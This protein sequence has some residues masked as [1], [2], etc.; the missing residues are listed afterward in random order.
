[1]L[2]KFL[3]A[4]YTVMSSFGHVRDLPQKKSDLP[5]AQQ[6]KPGAHM[7]IEIENDFSPMYVVPEASKKHVAA[8]KKEMGPQTT[9]VLASDEDRE[10]EAIAWHIREVLKPKK[11]NA[12]QRIVF[13]EITREAILH[14]IK[15][16]RQVNEHLVDAQQARRVLDRI[17]GYQLSPLL[18]R[19]IRTGLSAGRVQSVALRLVVERERERQAF[20]PEEFWKIAA[21][22][23]HEGVEFTAMFAKKN[24]KK[25]VP[26]NQEEANAIVAAA[27]GKPLVVGEVE[28]KKVNRNPAPPFTTSTMQQEASRKLGFSVKK[29]MMLAQK[30]YEGVALGRGASSG[31]ITYM[32]TDSVNLSGAALASAAQAI[33]KT[34]GKEY[35]QRRTFRTKSAN[36]QEAHEAIRPTDFSRSPSEIDALP[37]RTLTADA[38][39]LYGLIWRRALASQ[40][41]PAQ[42]LQTGADLNA[43]EGKNVF[44]FRATGQQV[45]FAGFFRA[46]TEGRDDGKNDSAEELLPPLET[47]SQ[48]RP[49]AINPTQH[50]T[51]PPARYTEASLVKK[52][53]ELGIGRPSTYAPTISTLLG[54]EYVEKEG[55]A[56]RPTDTGSAVCDFLVRNFA[57][58]V[59][60]GFTAKMEEGLD[61]IADN[62]SAF[63]AFLKKFYGHFT[64]EL[65]KGET[66]SR[67][68]AGARREIGDCP[69]TG[70][71]IYARLSRYGPCFQRGEA[72]DDDKPDFGPFLPGQRMEEV[73]LAD[74]LRSFALPRELGKDPQSGEA[75]SANMGRFGPYV[76]AGKTYAS[77]TADELFELDL[78][79]A[80]VKIAEKREAI[81]KRDV[82]SFEEEGIFVRRGRWGA[83][84][85]DGKKNAKV[86]PDTEP[87]NLTLE[88]C[89]KVLAAAPARRAGGRFGARKTGARA[90]AG[91]GKK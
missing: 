56:L 28:A 14:A 2:Q 58:I 50:F 51:Q 47:G 16:P 45:V 43:T 48:I 29:T 11:T 6:Q 90:G 35:A 40:M 22:C 42:L 57:H 62:K 72:T 26:K 74:A 10:G 80:L 70:K 15:S 31:L 76:R 37:D 85:T 23:S 13:H 9:L 34:F 20:T 30:L 5:A 77:I 44:S 78:A 60:F 59:S 71:K 41:K 55:R 27:K 4:G 53:E 21:E 69:Q 83:Y 75:L 38:K 91:R 86:P 33:T 1:M 3:G 66:L 81:A 89:Q 52:M 73:T 79:G 36:A 84:I 12:V 82:K 46:Y 25:C 68:D 87:E 39:K 54:R 67:D 32:R 18:W 65:E 24:G 64:A 7:G 19:K 61:G 63:A 17:V 88:Q 8:L 49:K